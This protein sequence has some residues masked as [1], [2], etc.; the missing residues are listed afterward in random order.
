MIC[1]ECGLPGLVLDSRE[2]KRDGANVPLYR[3]RRY[4]CPE[5]HRFSTAE[6]YWETLAQINEANKIVKKWGAL[7]RIMSE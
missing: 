5:G 4:E 1:P 7:K 6:V 2:I 3:R